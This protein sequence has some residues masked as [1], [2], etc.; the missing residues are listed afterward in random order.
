MDVPL[1]IVRQRTVTS[2]HGVTLT[3]A[4]CAHLKAKCAEGKQDSLG[5]S[6]SSDS[7]PPPFLE[8]H[9]SYLYIGCKNVSC[10]IESDS[11]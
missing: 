6:S 5:N 2:A 8:P 11:L 7:Q 4:L 3:L 10:T 9:F 1:S